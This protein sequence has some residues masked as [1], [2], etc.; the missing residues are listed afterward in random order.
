MFLQ[1]CICGKMYN[2]ELL[3]DRENDLFLRYTSLVNFHSQITTVCTISKGSPLKPN[4][5]YLYTPYWASSPHSFIIEVFI[6]ISVTL[7]LLLIFLSWW[8]FFLDRSFVHL[9]N[10]LMIS[11]WWF[12][13]VFISIIGKRRQVHLILRFSD[14]WLA[15]ITVKYNWFDGAERV[16]DINLPT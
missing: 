2:K 7:I 6:S 1:T 13:F 11:Q 10:N 15:V 14:F 3:Q 4:Y 16:S 9:I 5:A 12:G 8:C